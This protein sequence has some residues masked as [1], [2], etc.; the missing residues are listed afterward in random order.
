MEVGHSYCGRG[1]H[2]EQV[3][4]W[5]ATASMSSAWNR[6]AHKM[7][8]VMTAWQPVSLVRWRRAGRLMTAG[9]RLLRAGSSSISAR[10]AQ[11]VRSVL[12]VHLLPSCCAAQQQRSTPRAQLYDDIRGLSFRPE[13]KALLQP[14]QFNPADFMHTPAAALRTASRLLCRIKLTHMVSHAQPGH[15]KGLAEAS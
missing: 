6:R 9:P 1:M 4:G 10:A 7:W 2:G 15:P 11:S 5:Q 12:Q 3:E 13:A 14:G 8:A